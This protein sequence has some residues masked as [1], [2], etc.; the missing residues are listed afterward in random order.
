[1][2]RNKLL[3]FFTDPIWAVSV[4]IVRHPRIIRNDEVFIKWSFYHGLHRWPNLKD[5]KT[6]SEKLNW[7]KLHAK[8]PVYS[9][10]VDKYTAKKWI[11]EKKV[12][13]KVIPTLGVFDKFSD[14]DFDKLPNQFVLK[15][16]HDS[17]GL[18]ICK[19]KDAL[20]IAKAKEKI[21]R[22][23][24]TNFYLKNR[25]YPYKNVKP[26]IIAEKYMQDGSNAELKD[27]KFFCFDGK[28]SYCQVISDRS[29]DE[30]VDFYDMEWN[31]VEGLVGLSENL[32]NSSISIERPIMFD[33]M[34]E[35]VAILSKGIPFVR[36]DLYEINGD[37][38]FGE[39]T[40][41]PAA[42]FGRFYPDHWN[43]RFGEM[44]N[45]PKDF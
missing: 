29:T 43:L 20:N 45:L 17:G 35:V 34:K 32:H 25:E 16:T 15:C 9:T 38:Y 26:R 19:D 39:M 12:D 23:L 28:P 36:V 6:F 27:Y 10:L 30:N 8:N 42:G 24:Q 4:F 37:L 1:M 14:I 41:F 31:R 7:L 21:E 2:K 18:V 44:L 22:S 3:R 33:K 40:F 5:P 11:V 13:V